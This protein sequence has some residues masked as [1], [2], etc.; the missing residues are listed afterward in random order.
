MSKIKKLAGETVIY[1]IGA[2]LPKA[3][4]FLLVGSYLTFQ[5]NTDNYGI[6]NILYSF[7]TFALILFTLRME[8]TFFKF[9]SDKKHDESY[10]FNST[11]SV[12]LLS[13]SVLFGLM[14]LFKDKIA[15]FL[16]RPEDFRFVVYFAIILFL[17]AIASVPF[18][19]LRLDN[20][21]IKFSVIKVVNSLI[22]VGLIIFCFNILPH[23]DSLSFMYDESY[24]LDYTFLANLI[25]SSFIVMMLFKEL[26][27][28]RFT[29]NGELV[30]KMLDYAWPLIIVG[31]AGSINQFSD[32]IF[33][34][35]LADS[36]M[37][38]QNFDSAGLFSGALKVAVIM[39]LFVTAFNYAAEPFF[40]KNLNYDS[41][42]EAYGQIAL[43]FTVGACAIFLGVTFNIDII[44]YILDPAYHDTLFIVPI[45]LMSYFLLGLYYNFSIWYKLS[46]KTIYG[47]L[48]A[49][50]GSI[51]F[52]SLNFLLIPRFGLIGAN[53]GSLFC[54]LVMCIMA[55]LLGQKHYPIAYPI[56]KM[57]FYIALSIGLYF[58]LNYLG[59][60]GVIKILVGFIL[61]IGFLLYAYLVDLR[62]LLKTT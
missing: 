58:F 5:I 8:T 30:K 56:V 46:G 25:G 37:D 31:L 12:V 16:T 50:C 47:A 18:A 2:V 55:Y 14:I 33:I 6:Y 45:A 3:V 35:Y 54:F 61:L 17:D 26:Y 24:F 23:I 60:T 28:F 41:K 59:L 39:N 20:R 21:P 9:A 36:G 53:L 7:V 1:G 11:L 19:K 43:A 44:K 10:I 29:W 22:T 32:R 15:S 49:I 62:K 38:E 13:S 52:I 27:G 42:R 51:V 4:N 57:L 34:S 48:I 40:F